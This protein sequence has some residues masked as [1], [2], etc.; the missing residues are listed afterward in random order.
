[1]LFSYH[2][3]CIGKP[4][5]HADNT[6]WCGDVKINLGY[7][8]NTVD[9]EF[10]DLFTMVSEGGYALGPALK[11][12]HRVYNNFVS[13]NVALVDIDGGMK[14]DQLADFPFYAAFGAGYY[15][16]PSHTENDHRFRII[17]HLTKP[18]TDPETMQVLYLGLLAIHGAADISCKDPAR[19]FYGTVNA[20]RKEQTGRM[21]TEDGVEYILEEGLAYLPT[22]QPQAQIAIQNNFAPISNTKMSQ[23]LNDLRKYYAD[24]QYD[25]RFSVARAVANE[26]GI[27]SAIS[28]MRA[29]WD[30]SSKSVKYEQLLK[31]PLRVT[32]PD[33]GKIVN[34]IRVYDPQYMKA[35]LTQRQ[36]IKQAF[37]PNPAL[38]QYT[39]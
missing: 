33:A 19:L 25:V 20:V 39:F 14:L 21:L 35:P 30:D 7:N 27:A 31:D 16:T 34:M 3:T 15:T 24:L 13:H 2:N 4:I 18:V 9:L 5:K 32:S 37:G 38:K 26:I 10:N 11:S 1:M 8:W 36:L 6:L 12:D 28:E 17:Y 23:I 29:R 22:P